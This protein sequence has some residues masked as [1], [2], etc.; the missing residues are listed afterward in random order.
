M[1]LLS[2]SLCSTVVSHVQVE[3]GSTAPTM[4]RHL[5]KIR[6]RG[7][8]RDELDLAESPYTS[9]TECTEEVVIKPRVSVRE[10]EEPREAEG[11]Q[12]SYAQVRRHTC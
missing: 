3:T 1:F 11:D 2:S 12:Q 9:D 6:F 5:D 7:Q 4:R 8:R 10:A